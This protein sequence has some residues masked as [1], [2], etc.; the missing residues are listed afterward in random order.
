MLLTEA[1]R[2]G[3]SFSNA[4]GNSKERFAGAIK[5][6]QKTQHEKIVRGPRRKGRS[7]RAE[8]GKGREREGPK[9]KARRRSMT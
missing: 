6:L 7:G 9:K 3:S 2:V 8:S 1:V 4:K 5:D